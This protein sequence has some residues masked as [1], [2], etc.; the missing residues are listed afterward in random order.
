MSQIMKFI[1]SNEEFLNR[2]L[3]EAISPHIASLWLHYLLGIYLYMRKACVFVVRILE[4][5]L[6]KSA[7]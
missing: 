5:H 7:V 1:H 6:D 2:C 3:T 4:G